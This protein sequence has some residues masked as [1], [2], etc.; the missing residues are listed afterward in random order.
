MSTGDSFQRDKFEAWA[1]Q[2]IADAGLIS[3][4][5]LYARDALGSY[6]SATLQQLW[7]CW[8][9]AWHAAFEAG[10]ESG[11]LDYQIETDRMH[12]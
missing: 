11:A 2:H 1:Q 5:R 6:Q 9:A 12:E 10:E 7:D 3:S 8:S 4:K